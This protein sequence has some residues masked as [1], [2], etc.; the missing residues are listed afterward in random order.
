MTK[1]P[2]SYCPY[3]GT[4]LETRRSEGRDRR[5]CPECRSFVYRNPVPGGAVV[6][7]DGD[8][9][10]LIERAIPPDVGAWAVPGGILEVDESAQVGA[11]RELEEETGLSVDPDALELVRTG[12]EMDDPDA[13]SY[14]S[15]TF[16]VE[17]E[18]TRGS[19]VAG[20]EASDARFWPFAALREKRDTVRS[21]DR[22][23][24]EAAVERLRGETV[25]LAGE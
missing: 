22:N 19:V 7:L 23:R 11:A 15:I 12:F 8:A 6:V 3:C 13:G 10:L 16:A 9:A 18:H 1:R 20:A 5:Y 4:A 17:R 24:I 25:D 2:A 14:L 21:V